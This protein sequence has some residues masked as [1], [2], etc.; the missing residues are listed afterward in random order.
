MAN[1]TIADLRREVAQID[2][3]VADMPRGPIP[4]EQQLALASHALGLTM[5]TLRDVMDTLATEM[6]KS[7]I[8]G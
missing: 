7:T 1:M 8:R 4:I 3:Y 5:A 6:E 2:R